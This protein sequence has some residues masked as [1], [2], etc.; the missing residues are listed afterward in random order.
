MEKIYELYTVGLQIGG[1]D[2]DESYD[3]HDII[4][5]DEAEEKLTEKVREIFKGHMSAPIR[6]YTTV[7]SKLHLTHV[8]LLDTAASAQSGRKAVITTAYY[9]GCVPTGKTILGV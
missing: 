4:S 3:V 6:I 5:A 1:M 2:I 9:K 8:I 7:S